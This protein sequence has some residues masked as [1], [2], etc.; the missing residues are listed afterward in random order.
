MTK[1]LSKPIVA[2]LLLGALSACGT[3]E[4]LPL[5]EGRFAN[6]L[7]PTE[8]TLVYDYDG[9]IYAT[10]IVTDSSGV[11]RF[12]EELPADAVDCVIYAGHSIYGAYLEN[13]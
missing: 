11:F 3:K 5:L 1:N 8:L 6:V 7:E 10:D 9:D 2:A 13:G 12:D 4:K